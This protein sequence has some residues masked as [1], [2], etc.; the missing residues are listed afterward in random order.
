MHRFWPILYYPFALAVLLFAA[1]MCSM[2]IQYFPP[3]KEVLFLTTKA[4]EAIST[5][6]YQ[7]S[8]YIHITTSIVALVSGVFQ[9]AGFLI[10]DHPTFHRYTGYV[11]VVTI[12]LLAAPGGFYI[13][14]FANGGLSSRVGFYCLSLAWWLTTFKAYRMAVQ[15][16]FREHIIWMRRSYAITLAAMSLRTEGYILNFLKVGGPI[17]TY[18]TLSWLSW[19]GN[20]FILELL[21]SMGLGD[22]LFKY[23][24]KSVKIK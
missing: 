22:S 14:Q 11:Y 4:T 19:V 16:K 18:A 21:L 13:S 23:I 7:W 5:P 8:F 12:L 3:G 20:L 17:E 1:V 6:F 15:K 2:V 9:F 10:K 24:F